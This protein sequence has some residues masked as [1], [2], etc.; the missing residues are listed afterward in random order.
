VDHA[1]ITPRQAE[2][3][4]HVILGASLVDVAKQLALS[5]ETVK[6]HVRRTHAVVG[7]HTLHGLAVWAHSHRGC[8]LAGELLSN[9]PDRA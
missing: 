1:R 5:R 3:L 6:M 4:T 9:T 7:T 8:C 2:V